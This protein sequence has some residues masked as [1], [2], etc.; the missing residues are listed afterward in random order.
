MH[1]PEQP[2]RVDREPCSGGSAEQ[3]AKQCRRERLRVGPAAGCVPLLDLLKVDLL[4][5]VKRAKHARFSCVQLVDGGQ[6]D[7]SSYAGKILILPERF[8]EAC[9]RLPCDHD[10]PSF[11]ATAVTQVIR[12]SVKSSLLAAISPRRCGSWV[13]QVFVHRLSLPPEKRGCA[14]CPQCI[15]SRGKCHVRVVQGNLVPPDRSG[16]RS[17]DQNHRKQTRPHQPQSDITLAS[18]CHQRGIARP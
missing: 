16:G 18:L 5:R 6:L 9:V 12:G 2:S 17:R 1:V 8:Q 7:A 4:E 13:Q 15:R 10:K 3:S 14:L 11:H